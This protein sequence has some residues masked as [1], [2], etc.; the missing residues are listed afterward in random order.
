MTSDS[1]GDRMKAYENTTRSL[2]GR[3]SYSILR[4]D[5]K[6]FH[7]YTRRLAKPFDVGLVRSIDAS[8]LM[9][10]GEVQGACFAYAQ[11]DEI[12]VL[13]TDLKNENSDLWFGG[14]VQKITSV[15]AS[16]F[17]S[18]F[19]RER[20]NFKPAYFDCRVFQVPSRDEVNNYFRWRNLDCFRNGVS[21]IA[22]TLY[23][24]K[25]LHGKSTKDRLQMISEAG[26]YIL[27]EDYRNVYGGISFKDENGLWV[28]DTAW[29]FV[30]DNGRLLSKF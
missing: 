2:L 7:T 24:D 21:A 1:L 15:A 6:A 17:T 27:P 18:A 22:N 11:S 25:E 30:E 23:S 19:N 20:I 14:N 4:I 16:V 10:L 28:Q 5:G 3:K 29:Y 8:I 9:L 13:F 12:S 26:Y